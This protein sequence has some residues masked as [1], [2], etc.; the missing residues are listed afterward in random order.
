MRDDDWS[1]VYCNQ[2]KW[3]SV[4]PLAGAVDWGT[5]NN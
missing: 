1:L 2:R 3:G 5:V 4:T